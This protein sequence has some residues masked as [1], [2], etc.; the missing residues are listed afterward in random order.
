M[1]GKVRTAEKGAKA[2]RRVGM[3][4]YRIDKVRGATVLTET[5]PSQNHP[6]AVSKDAYAVI[7]NSLRE[8]GKP[9]FRELHGAV[10]RNLGHK[11]P[12]YAIRVTVRF[13]LQAPPL[14][15][16][17]RARYIPTSP[18]TFVRDTVLRWEKLAASKT[19]AAD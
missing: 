4:A 1:L 16:R 15:K 6:Y 9:D 17:A 8:L 18:K 10:E 11:V 12:E 19:P 14:I 13:W 7:A 5:R 3:A 2:S